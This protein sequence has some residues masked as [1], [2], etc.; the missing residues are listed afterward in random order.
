MDLLSK[1]GF[2]GHKYFLITTEDQSWNVTSTNDDSLFENS[3]NDKNYNVNQPLNSNWC[4][5]C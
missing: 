2:L 5:C 4:G 3:K 1:I